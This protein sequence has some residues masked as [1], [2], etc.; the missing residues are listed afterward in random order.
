MSRIRAKGSSIR[1][2]ALALIALA[3]TA[4]A[5][6]AVAATSTS[7]SAPPPAGHASAAATKNA[8]PAAPAELID[9]NSASPAQLKTLPGIGDAEAAKIIA[10]R[11]YLSKAELV[12]KNVVGTG[13]YMSIKKR[14]VALQTSQPKAKQ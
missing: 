8:A 11:P 12:T 14:I 13:P 6:Q 5:G 1:A 3:G 2:I 7:A 4:A 9:I 10:A